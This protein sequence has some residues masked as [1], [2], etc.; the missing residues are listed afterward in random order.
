MS[1]N[2]NNSNILV[3]LS[4]TLRDCTDKKLAWTTLVSNVSKNET[5]KQVISKQDDKVNDKN[6]KI[7]RYLEV[8]GCVIDEVGRS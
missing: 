8:E 3:W 1:N 4:V 7:L 5:L 2:N 6:K